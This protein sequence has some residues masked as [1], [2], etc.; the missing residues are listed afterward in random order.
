[1]TNHYH[2]LLQTLEPNLSRAMQWL[3]VS[4][5]AWFNRRHD[6]SGHLLQGRFG[7]VIVQA[8]T[9]AWSLSR[10]IHLNPVRVKRFGW[11]K[12]VRQQDRLG[13][14]EAP[15]PELIQKRLDH[16]RAYRWSSYRAFAG[17]EQAP[18]WLDCEG[19]LRFSGAPRAQRH[20]A[21][22]QACEECLKQGTLQRPWPDLIQRSILGSLEFAQSL[23]EK[24]KGRIAP[25]LDALKRRPQWKQILAAIEKMK[26]QPWKEFRD[27]HGDWGRDLALYLGRETGALTW[28]ELGNEAALPNP[29]A[30][31]MAVQRFEVKM[32]KD[33]DLLRKRE[34]L[35]RQLWNVEC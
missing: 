18:E 4:Y 33:P 20:K 13:I 7:S 22:R 12:Q 34:K 21:Y 29:K 11:D 14:G 31:A 17:L 6:R 30:A 28:R 10:Y 32:N 25:A 9:W 1:M 15:T 19:V 3:N 26:N 5:C 27:R 23:R 8:E 16:L 35:E 24:T 2:L